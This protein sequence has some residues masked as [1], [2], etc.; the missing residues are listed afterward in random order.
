MKRR[1]SALF[2]FL[3]ANFR[4]AFLAVACNIHNCEFCAKLH[5]VSHYSYKN[6]LIALLSAITRRVIVIVYS[7]M[8]REMFIN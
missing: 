2:S 4:T 7:S 3:S 1:I 8:E 6:L 5:V